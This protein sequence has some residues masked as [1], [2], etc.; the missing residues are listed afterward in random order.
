[1]PIYI[2]TT[3]FILCWVC[4]ASNRADIAESC[5]QMARVET[6]E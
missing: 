4:S 6:E 1:M 2:K 3:R 5:Y